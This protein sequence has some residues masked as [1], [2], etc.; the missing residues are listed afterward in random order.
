MRHKLLK[1][2]HSVETIK[3]DISKNVWQ[4]IRRERDKKHAFQSNSYKNIVNIDVV[5]DV[6]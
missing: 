6:D 4:T 3:V 1:P 5:V 2:K